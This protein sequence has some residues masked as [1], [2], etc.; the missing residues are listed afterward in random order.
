MR[1]VL[2]ICVLVLFS[3]VTTSAASD[4]NGVFESNRSAADV[5]LSTDPALPFWRAARP[6]YADRGPLGQ[7][8]P[9][10]RTEIRSRW[11]EKN[12]YF[13]FVCPYQELNLKPSPATSTETYGLWNWD[14]AEVFIG[15]DFENIRHYKEFEISPQGEWIDLDI[16][17]T[18]PHHEDGWKWNSGFAVA[19]RIDAAA[20]VWYGAMRI[21]ISALQDRP[22]SA[23]E[24][25]RVNLFRSQGPAASRVQITWQ[26]TMSSTFHVPEK[27]GILRLVDAS[28]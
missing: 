19:A 16:D 20:K 28:N 10:Y 12:L 21:P 17:L 5:P 15:S 18:S 9:P 22:P 3:A 8:E 24:G 23:G 1:F 25:F 27:F 14:V 26:P 7:S 11:T 13:L 6:I 4:D 2:T